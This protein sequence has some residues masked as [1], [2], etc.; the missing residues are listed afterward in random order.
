[1]WSW[2][3]PCAF[4]SHS[5]HFRVSSVEEAEEMRDWDITV[6]TEVEKAEEVEGEGVGRFEL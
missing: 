1:M 4:S 6:G 3:M 2:M 5:I